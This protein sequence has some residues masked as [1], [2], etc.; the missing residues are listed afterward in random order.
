MSLLNRIFVSFAIEDERFRILF[1]GQ[2]KLE[3]SPFEFTDMSVKAPWDEKWK[4]QCRSRI[5]GCDGVIALVS[6]NTK[7][8]DG[9]LWELRTAKEEH[10]PIRGIYTTVDARPASL[11]SEFNGVRVVAWTWPNIQSFLDSL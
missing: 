7:D 5:K 11:P 2:A 9:Q 6:K 4:T 1:G 3:K 8:A 10:V